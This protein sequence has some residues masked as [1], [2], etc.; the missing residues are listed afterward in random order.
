MVSCLPDGEQRR[1]RHTRASPRLAPL[2]PCLMADLSLIDHTFG[3]QAVLGMHTQPD[4]GCRTD[5]RE[6]GASYSR[7][8]ETTHTCTAAPR[9]NTTP[10]HTPLSP[11]GRHGRAPRLD[12]TPAGH[13]PGGGRGRGRGVEAPAPSGAATQSSTLCPGRPAPHRYTRHPPTANT[14]NTL[15][16]H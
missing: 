15:T 8:T 13:S 2:G 14:R 3:R 7:N 10:P 12:V 11:H 6:V 4:A 1:A 5:G 16:S 9:V